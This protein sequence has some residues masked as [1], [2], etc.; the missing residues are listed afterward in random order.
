VILSCVIPSLVHQAE[1]GVSP[2]GAFEAKGGPLSPRIDLGR[3]NSANADSKIGLTALPSG[4]RT[5]SQR[6]RKREKASMRVSGYTRVPSL[7]L[8]WPLKST[9]QVSFGPSHAA[10]G[11]VKAGTR[12]LGFRV[13]V[14]PCRRRMAVIV[15]GLGIS[16]SET[17]R[18]SHFPAWIRRLIHV[19]SFLE[20]QRG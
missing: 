7:V 5:S 13:S 17:R 18:R 11:C 19:Y 8:K 16:R 10:K 1:R 4:S 3:P 12:C 2:P 15:L 20:P 14:S 6:R 9:H